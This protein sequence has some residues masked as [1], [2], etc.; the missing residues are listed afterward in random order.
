MAEAVCSHRDIIEVFEG[1]DQGLH[2]KVI[3]NT[4]DAVYEQMQQPTYIFCVTRC[5]QC[6]KELDVNYLG[7]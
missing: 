4:K 1:H 2:T 6:H 3:A 5:A 7:C